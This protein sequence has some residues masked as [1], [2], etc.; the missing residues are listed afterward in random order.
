MSEGDLR[1][2]DVLARVI[3]T[4]RQGGDV[5]DEDRR[6]V[7]SCPQCSRVIAAAAQLEDELRAADVRLG[8]AGDALTRATREAQAAARVDEWRRAAFIALGALA[9]VIPRLMMPEGPGLHV[10]GMLFQAFGALVGLGAVG[11]LILR[12]LNVAMAPKGLYTR[13][14]GAWFFGVCR[15]LAEAAGLPVLVIRGAFIALLFLGKVGWLIAVP[16]YLLL[17]M[18]MEVH[19]EDRELLLRFRLKRWWSGDAAALPR[20]DRQS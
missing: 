6:H 11:S 17:E 2:E 9:V 19:P 20:A 1:C 14:R 15:G 16:L 5:A 10:T 8:A 7:A 13:L 4:L 18:S 3:A 12:R